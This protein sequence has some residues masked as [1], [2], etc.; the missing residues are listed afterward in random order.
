LSFNISY[1]PYSVDLPNPNL[2]DTRRFSSQGLKRRTPGGVVKYFKDSDWPVV[3]TFIYD[4][5]RLTQTE[6]NDLLELLE[7]GAG[8]EIST[9]DHHG[10]ARTGY[11]V[12]PVAEIVT[13]RD[14]CFYDAHFEYM[15]NIIVNVTGD[16]PE[17]ATPDTPVP[18]DADY[19]QTLDN[20]DFYRIY[21][22]DNDPME[23]EDDSPIYIEAF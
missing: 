18:G 2:E 1:S 17:D 12:T 7:A 22:E 21:A 16:C 8:L 11:I 6:R 13:V 3:E 19:H 5:V 23:A 9:T 14:D 15:A 10:A 20:D 4:F